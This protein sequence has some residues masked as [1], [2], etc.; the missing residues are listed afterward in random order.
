MLNTVVSNILVQFMTII[1]GVLLARFLGPE[2]R[3]SLA[4]IVFF[5]QLCMAL[6][7]IGFDRGFAIAASNNIISKPLI[8]VSVFSLAF[9][10]V[11]AITSVVLINFRLGDSDVKDLAL[12]YSFYI[13]PVSFFLLACGYF[14]GKGY[15]SGYNLSRLTFYA[16]N[17][18]LL[19]LIF[20]LGKKADLPC[21]VFANL[22]S[23]YVVGLVSFFFL[24]RVTGCFLKD[25]VV[26]Q[27]TLDGL[28]SNGEDGRKRRYWPKCFVDLSD[29]FVSIFKPSKRFIPL[30]GLSHICSSI[31]QYLAVSILEPSLIGLFVINL[32]YA[33]LGSGLS[34]AV[35]VHLFYES[36]SDNYSEFYE[37]FRSASV[38]FFLVALFLL[39]IAEP[40]VK[41]VF[42]DGFFLSLE[43]LAI[44]IAAGFFSQTSEVLSEFLRGRQ[45]FRPEISSL[46]FQ[47]LLLLPFGL[48]LTSGV[49]VIGL[50]VA[51]LFSEILRL[52]LLVLLGSKVGAFDISSLVGFRMNDIKRAVKIFEGIWRKRSVD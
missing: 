48:V 45:I 2:G 8:S 5:P 52:L 42:G 31:P 29:D 51:I 30:L 24:V 28:T 16:S 25:S 33:K 34:N 3:G 38:V 11:A 6:S 50:S 18:A 41:L 15:F 36:M 9:A 4:I 49:Q 22:A 13:P 44:L 19:L 27:S 43:L 26:K 32:T 47:S 20:F 37:K 17:L 1:T 21:V 39:S 14:N 40:V 7:L 23:G 35:G 10:I 46:I 12:L